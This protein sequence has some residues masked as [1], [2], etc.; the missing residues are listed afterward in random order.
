MS[1][2]RKAVSRDM[3]N[4]FR[5]V[6]ITSAVFT[7]TVGLTA[8]GDDDEGGS[9]NAQALIDAMVSEGA[10]EEEARCLVDELGDD[11]ERLWTSD[12]AD[13]SEEDMEKFE[14]AL[15]ECGIIE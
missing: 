12:D 2:G 13:L 9:S 7:L 10:P 14:E 15:K 1:L 8:C 5:V 6:L 4:F 3:P 11:A